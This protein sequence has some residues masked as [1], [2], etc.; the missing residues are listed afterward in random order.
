MEKTT[1]S[2][3][4]SEPSCHFT[5][6]LRLNTHTVGLVCFQLAARAGRISSFLPRV[7]SGS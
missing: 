3:V 2:A 1:S 4:K 5:P 7:T 6:F